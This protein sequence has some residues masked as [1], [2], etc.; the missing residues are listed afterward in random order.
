M[1]VP[2]GSKLLRTSVKGGTSPEQSVTFGIFR[3]PEV[4]VRQAMTICHPFDSCRV[5]P[6]C[7]LRAMAFNLIEGPVGVMKHRLATLQQWKVW[8]KELEKAELEI[9][10][11][12]P[13]HMQTVMEGKKLL[14]LER[15]ANSLNWPDEKIHEH[16]R[17]GFRL[18][19]HPEVSGIFAK[20]TVPASMTEDELNSK[21]PTMR[22]ALWERIRCSADQEHESTIWD[23]TMEECH[24]KGWLDGPYNW[25][26]LG[27]K[28]GHQ[29]LP[30]KRFGVWQRNKWRPI[31]DF[32][33]NGVN[34]CYSVVEKIDLRALDETVWVCAAFLRSTLA[35]GAVDFE[36]SDG[37]KIR[38]KVRTFWRRKTGAADVKIKTVDLASAYKQLG[39]SEIDRSKAVV[40]LRKP[41][42]REVYGFVCNTLPFGATSS[43]ICFNRFARLT[44]RI[45][46][47]LNVVSLN[48]FDDYPVVELSALSQ[49]TERTVAAALDMLGI[50]RARDKDLPFSGSAELL[51][52]CLDA[53]DPDGK[54][55]KVWNKKDRTL[56]MVEALDDILLSGRVR[57]REL[58]SVFWES[59]VC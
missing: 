38:G 46:V 7:V 17:Q 48:Y 10:A 2:Q 56:K 11:N 27:N 13:A 35:T 59:T 53:S 30:C 23:I 36:L 34:S 20:T 28:F 32:S 12:M 5:V 14:L 45:L 49:N 40:S 39:L 50:W 58:P 54:E 21:M 52:V 8:A 16:L 3:A 47:A 55:V 6:D 9:H 51:G 18:V 57:P 43:V 37:T 4:F 41:G 31:D 44:Q 24:T 1:N 15:I 19:G 29:W 26:E 42:T 33:D 22:C 25:A